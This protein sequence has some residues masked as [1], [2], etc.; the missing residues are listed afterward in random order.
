[1]F[2]QICTI[3]RAGEQPEHL[4]ELAAGEPMRQSQA[5][6]EWAAER[7]TAVPS[8]AIGSFEYCTPGADVGTVPVCMPRGIATLDFVAPADT[9]T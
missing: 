2:A 6:R 5:E 3:P 7:S 1:M 4:D 9:R 8:E